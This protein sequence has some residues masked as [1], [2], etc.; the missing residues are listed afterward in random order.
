MTGAPSPEAARVLMYG[1]PGC[2]LCDVARETIRAVCAELGE[3]WEE[4]D[5]SADDELMRRYG[6]EIP[7]TLVDGRQHDFWRVDARRLRGALT[8]SG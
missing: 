8:A 6:E 3:S 2:H 1:K 7:V 4:V 5:I